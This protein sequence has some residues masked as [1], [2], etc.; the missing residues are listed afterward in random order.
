MARRD[1][2]CEDVLLGKLGVKTVY[3]DDN[4]LAFHHPRPVAEIHVVVIP[5]KHVPSILDETA[6]DGDLLSSMVR[7]IQ[8]TADSLGLGDGRGFYV[9]ANAACSSS[10]RYMQACANG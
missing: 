8:A 6:L 3:E 9:R 5:K 1:W 2:Y 7:A 10:T 4:V